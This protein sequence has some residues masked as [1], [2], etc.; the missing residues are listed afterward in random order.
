MWERHK[1][2]AGRVSVPPVPDQM[3]A[4]ASAVV[5]VAKEHGKKKA[6]DQAERAYLLMPK[7]L[8]TRVQDE[9]GE[10]SH[11]VTHR[12]TGRIARTGYR[13]WS[14]RMTEPYWVN[15][16]DEMCS[17]RSVFAFEWTNKD[18]VMA[19]K[20]VTADMSELDDYVPGLDLQ[21]AALDFGML[22]PDFLG[23]VVQYETMNGADCDQL[24]DD[25]REFGAQSLRDVQYSRTLK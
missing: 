6:S 25:V 13:R 11:H 24:I 17:Y 1:R 18:V 19:V 20:R 8:E 15:T 21:P 10:Y 12:F 2:K 3:H 14:M 16:E 5:C 22:Q 4:L 9:A 23:A 7:K